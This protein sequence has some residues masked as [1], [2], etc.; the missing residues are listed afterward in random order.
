MKKYLAIFL[1]ASAA[2]AQTPPSSIR[3]PVP[4][5]ISVV[6]PSPDT[7]P[8]TEPAPVATPS[9]PPL[10][11]I[12]IGGG[13]QNQPSTPPAAL[14]LPTPASARPTP[15]A[16]PLPPVKAP[17]A[18]PKG[19]MATPIATPETKP[20]SPLIEDPV[21]P[22]AGNASAATTSQPVIKEPAASPSPA[23][24]EI[25][26]PAPKDSPPPMSPAKP[27]MPT[28]APKA[29]APA[30]TPPNV[31]VNPPSAT[32]DQPVPVEESPF[33]DV[34]QKVEEAVVDNSLRDI[35]KFTDAPFLAVMRLLAKQAGLSYVEPVFR[36]G[37]EPNL[38]IELFNVTP[39][40][41]FKI[42][43]EYRGFAVT[44]YD[45]IYTLDRPDLVGTQAMVTKK[46]RLRWLNPMW[47]LQEIANMLGIEIEKP[48]TNL[49]TFP[50]P[51]D[52]YSSGSGGSTGG[53]GGATGGEGGGGGSEVP[54]AD[55]SGNSIVGLPDKPR[56]TTTLPYDNPASK[57]GFLQEQSGQESVVFVDRRDNGI[58]VRATRSEHRVIEKY[59]IEN[60]KPE[61]QL[62][63]DVQV[64]EVTADNNLTQGI[65]W[66][67]ALGKEGGLTVKLDSENIGT[68]SFDPI[69]FAWNPTGV[70]VSLT[71]AEATINDF[72]QKNK[73]KALS[74]PRV[75][76]KSGVPVTIRSGVADPVAQYTSVGNTGGG[77]GVADNVNNNF[78]T[79]YTFFTTGI[80][81]DLVGTIFQ[82][83]FLDLNVNAVVS[84]RIGQK[85]INRQEVP[86]IS[87]RA[88]ATTV[89]V[90]SG[91]TVVLGGL[92]EM[93]SDYS[94]GGIPPFDKVP[95]LGD[96]IFG[97]KNE[98]KSRKNLIVF[99]TPTI[100]YPNYQPTMKLGPQEADAISAGERHDTPFEA[101]PVP[102]LNRPPESPKKSTRSQKMEMVPAIRKPLPKSPRQ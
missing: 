43:A 60:D 41:A 20:V 67:K 80:V 71:N 37:D 16:V 14:A 10:A 101:V 33:L 36:N 13:A 12:P 21:I 6:A 47:T 92:Y 52:Q 58:I 82:D 98:T 66:A 102:N 18:V 7:A 3:P 30:G 68:L 35:I 11:P 38:T 28:P 78:N 31:T 2:V 81:M 77:T 88:V 61:A 15:P 49:R 96:L 63:I 95:I 74:V 85:E 17:V 1:A 55:G 93:L 76:T 72:V 59:L 79:S 26:T 75:V 39:F 86:I 5:P 46:Y 44:S 40:D 91:Q 56:W 62:A 69:N 89:T 45:N 99:V 90:R 32:G 19:V 83:G 53:G 34:G 4:M 100:V 22:V 94:G 27:D 84:R 70:V 65:S 50:E 29:P 42:I 51:E 87:T 64:V 24:P 8:K 57:G 73:G 25:A 9:I 97:N 54:G 48:D 23:R